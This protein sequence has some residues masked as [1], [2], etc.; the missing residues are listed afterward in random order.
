MQG[1]S[2]TWNLPTR[3]YGGPK[4]KLIDIVDGQYEIVLTV[5]SVTGSTATKKVIVSA[6]IGSVKTLVAAQGT[7]NL[8]YADGSQ[9][10][11]TI[12]LSIG[13]WVVKNSAGQIIQ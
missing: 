12:E 4:K 5:K 6:K 9:E 2:S 1:R 7:V 8:T 11:G 10:I 3:S 13:K